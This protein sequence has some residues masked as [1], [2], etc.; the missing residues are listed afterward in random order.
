MLRKNSLKYVGIALLGFS[1]FE[2]STASELAVSQKT[3]SSD[4]KTPFN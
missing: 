1:L 2:A 4:P 3:D